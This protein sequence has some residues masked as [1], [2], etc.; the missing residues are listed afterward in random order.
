M[1]VAA[2]EVIIPE[3]FLNKK[4]IVGPCALERLS[5]MYFVALSTGSGSMIDAP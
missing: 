4:G 3:L 1:V 2:V 5:I